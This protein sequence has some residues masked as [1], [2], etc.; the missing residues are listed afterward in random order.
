MLQT[1]NTNTCSIEFLAGSLRDDWNTPLPVR[2]TQII[3]ISSAFHWGWH[4]GGAQCV[5]SNCAVRSHWGQ[6]NPNW[7]L[8]SQ[9]ASL[10]HILASWNGLKKRQNR[11]T[12]VVYLGKMWPPPHP[13]P[14]PIKVTESRYQW[15]E[16]ATGNPT[17]SDGPGA[18][19]PEGKAGRT[20]S[21]SHLGL[22]AS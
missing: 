16:A 22:T 10:L 9:F 18:F 8:P 13:L 20:A 11:D 14:L 21:T 4:T 5:N 2:N 15:K 6:R 19:A 17:C 12:E 3:R 1:V 7:V